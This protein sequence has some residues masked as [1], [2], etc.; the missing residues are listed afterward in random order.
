MTVTIYKGYSIKTVGISQYIYR[1]LPKVLTKNILFACCDGYE[2]SMFAAK[3][4]INAD[5]KA[6]KFGS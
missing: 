3:R 1:D 4:W 2:Q 6:R 5:L